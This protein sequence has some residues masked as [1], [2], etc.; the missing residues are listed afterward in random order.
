MSG[1]SPTFGMT[2]KEYAA[3]KRKRTPDSSQEGGNFGPSAKETKQGGS[4][5]TAQ[6]KADSKYR[7]ARSAAKAAAVKK[8]RAE[9]E[10]KA[11]TRRHQE[12]VKKKNLYFDK[13]EA[14]HN[15]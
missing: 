14:V 8:A 3:W 7:K 12:S 13:R 2:A 1:R 4:K 10:K 6:K 9:R 5:T 15:A 11:K